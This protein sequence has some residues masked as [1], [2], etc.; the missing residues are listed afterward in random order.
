MTKK[1]KGFEAGEQDYD[2]QLGVM[3]SVVDPSM[4]RLANLFRV[5]YGP[6]S[7]VLLVVVPDPEEFPDNE[8]SYAI[9]GSLDADSTIQASRADHLRAAADTLEQEELRPRA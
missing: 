1:T 6:K 8:G 9:F 4:E 7:D 3:L 5:A 2:D